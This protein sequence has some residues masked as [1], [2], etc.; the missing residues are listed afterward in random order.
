MPLRGISRMKCL[1]A[2]LMDSWSGLVERY[3]S[4]MQLLRIGNPVPLMDF[5]KKYMAEP[6]TESGIHERISNRLPRASYVVESAWP[7]EILRLLT[8]DVQETEMYSA[9]WAWSRSGECRRLH[10]CRSYSW[11]DLEKLQEDWKVN[12]NQVL[13]DSGFATR[14]VYAA[15]ISATPPLRPPVD[16]RG[17]QRDGHLVSDDGL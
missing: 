17:A 11:T 2:V 13:I 3:L 16:H 7:D 8:V 1:N 9:V 15:G 5:F 14:R 12:D 6:T 4:A 10:I